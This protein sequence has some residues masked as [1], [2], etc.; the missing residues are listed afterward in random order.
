MGGRDKPESRRNEKA[1]RDLCVCFGS[2]ESFKEGR[3]EGKGSA[4]NRPN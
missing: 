2:A 3:G 4:G 1:K